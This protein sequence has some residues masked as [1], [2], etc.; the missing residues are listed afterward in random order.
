MTDTLADALPHIAT[1]DPRL[2]GWN[3]AIEAAARKVEVHN[4][5]RNKDRADRMLASAPSP[6]PTSPRRAKTMTSEAPDRISISP[7]YRQKRADDYYLVDRE[8]FP[9]KGVE[10]IRADHAKAMV[11]AER[12]ACAA[13]IENNRAH[14]NF[15][16]MLALLRDT[17]L[18]EPVVVAVSKLLDGIATEVRARTPDDAQAALDA[19]LKAE[20]VKALDVGN[21]LEPV[22]RA[23]RHIEACLTFPVSTEID[24][25]GYSTRTPTPETVQYIVDEIFQSRVALRALADAGEAGE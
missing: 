23:L 4:L 21:E 11:A 25:R 15:N 1:P 24:K 14:L 22:D 13:K 18:P 10:Y 3:A 20:R 17:P 8:A 6:A 16:A 2:E 9:G 7:V 12:E 19:L 5:G